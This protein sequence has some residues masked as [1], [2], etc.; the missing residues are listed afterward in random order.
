MRVTEEIAESHGVTLDMVLGPER[1]DHIVRA[2]EHALAVVRWSTGLS[3]PAIGNIFDRDHSTVMS[4]VR[5]YE[6][7]LNGKRRPRR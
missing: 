1:S 6:A 3:F 2:R 7:M 4:A 5:R